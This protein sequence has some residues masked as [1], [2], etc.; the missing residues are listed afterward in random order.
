MEVIRLALTF[1]G[2]IVII[3]LCDAIS[4]EEINRSNVAT[5]IFTIVYAITIGFMWC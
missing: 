3:G 2:I 4:R 1:I 5:L